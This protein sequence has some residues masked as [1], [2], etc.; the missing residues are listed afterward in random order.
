MINRSVLSRA[1][2]GAVRTKR[3]TRIKVWVFMHDLSIFPVWAAREILVEILTP[4]PCDDYPCT[5]IA[6]IIATAPY[7]LAR[8]FEWDRD[9]K[10]LPGAFVQQMM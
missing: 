7:L 9:T 2:T 4:L 1:N 5:K 6:R 3:K 10:F 8:T